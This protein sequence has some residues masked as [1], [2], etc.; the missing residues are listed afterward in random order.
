M[1]KTAKKANKVSPARGAR[2]KLHIVVCIKPVPDPAAWSK[3]RLHP[4]T[5]LLNRAE[6]GAVI[7]PLDLNAIEQALAIKEASAAGISV[8]TMAPPAAEDQLREALAMGCDEAY[9][10]SDRAFAGADTLSTARCLAAAIRKIGDVDL[11]FC[12]AYSADGSTAQVGPQIAELLEMPDLTHVVGIEMVPGGLRVVCKVEDGTVAAECGF[13]ALL[14]FDREANRP[15]LAT[16]PGIRRARGLAVISWTATDLG[17]DPALTGL[18]GSPT[19]MLNVFTQPT[20]R[21][22]EM[23]SGSAAEMAENLL[24]RLHAAKVLE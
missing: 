13:P 19:Q 5:M 22:G 7:N 17:L 16:M 15:R 4:D 6:L 11:V 2:T 12:G 14:T 1:A 18:Q 20:G 10:A 24:A 9:L 3:L 21:K 8:L 23:L